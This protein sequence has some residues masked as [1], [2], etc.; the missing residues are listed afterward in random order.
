[1][2]QIIEMQR[3]DT[4]EAGTVEGGLWCELF[5]GMVVAQLAFIPATGGLS[6]AG[7]P[8]TGAA[9]LIACSIES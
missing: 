9:A 8:L 2:T 1:M 5:T 4:T 7:L 6:G 3:I